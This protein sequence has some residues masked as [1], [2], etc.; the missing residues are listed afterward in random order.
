MKQEF[1][2][3]SL[4]LIDQEMEMSTLGLIDGAGR[5]FVSAVLAYRH[6]GLKEFWIS[7]GLDSKKV[8]CIKNNKNAGLCYYNDS[9]NVTLSGVAE[10]ITDADVKKEMWEDWMSNYYDSPTHE[11][12]CLIKLTIKNARLFM[13]GENVDLDINEIV[14]VS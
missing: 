5:P 10:V 6:T 1:I 12:Y 2:K 7:T 4:E 13:N 11:L 8:E 14:E 9:V 3:K